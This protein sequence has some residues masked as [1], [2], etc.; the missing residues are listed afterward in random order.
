MHSY[1]DLIVQHYKVEEFLHDSAR[2]KVSNKNS[3]FLFSLLY[4]SMNLLTTTLNWLPHVML[5]MLYYLYREIATVTWRF[6]TSFHKLPPYHP[7]SFLFA[8]VDAFFLIILYET[9]SLH[10]RSRYV[11]CD[12]EDLILTLNTTW[13]WW[14][15][16]A[17]GLTYER[18]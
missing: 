2:F 16:F 9:F 13:W 15:V 18:R 1:P 14:I 6:E 4:F 12:S 7:S 10:L 5:L 8:Y 17:E 11:K 3:W